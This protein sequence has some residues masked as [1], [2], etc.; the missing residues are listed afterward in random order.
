MRF[1]RW[2]VATTD[3]GRYNT[4]ANT[5]IRYK[6]SN[7]L[8]R[9]DDFPLPIS[10]APILRFWQRVHSPAKGTTSIWERDSPYDSRLINRSSVPCLRVDELSQHVEGRFL[11][12]VAGERRRPWRQ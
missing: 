10:A 3:C 4:A 9:N 8:C 1:N 7:H 2:F 11:H 6:L 5:Y 12:K